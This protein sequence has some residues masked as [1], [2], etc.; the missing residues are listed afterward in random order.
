MINNRLE[1]RLL[2]ICILRLT[3]AGTALALPATRRAPSALVRHVSTMALTS[4]IGAQGG[5]HAI[6]AGP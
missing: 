3:G 6:R 5:R 4:L 1:C 2:G